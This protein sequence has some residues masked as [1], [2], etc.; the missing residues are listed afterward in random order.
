MDV[1]SKQVKVKLIVVELKSHPQH[2]LAL[3][4][5]VALLHTCMLA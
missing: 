3:P 5:K 4:G 2:V 1:E